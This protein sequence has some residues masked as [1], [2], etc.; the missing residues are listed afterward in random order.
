ML[1]S[2]AQAAPP[3]KA[4]P[5]HSRRGSASRSPPPPPPPCEAATFSIYKRAFG[6]ARRRSGAIKWH[7]R[8]ARVSSFLPNLSLNCGITVTQQRPTKI[9]APCFLLRTPFGRNPV[10]VMEGAISP[11]SS[12]VEKERESSS[13]LSCPI[14]PTFPVSPSRLAPFLAHQ[15]PSPISSPAPP[16]LLFGRGFSAPPQNGKKVSLLFVKN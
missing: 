11:Q 5:A 1:T 4:T 14:G 6:M 7:R 2:P 15:A 13:L 12:C 9:P 8:L 16:L 3:P 10:V